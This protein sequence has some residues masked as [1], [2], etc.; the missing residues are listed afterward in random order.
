MTTT[1]LNLSTQ[2]Q[3]RKGKTAFADI[4][5]GKSNRMVLKEVVQVKTEKSRHQ[6]AVSIR[7]QLKYVVKT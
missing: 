3:I 1:K 2:I 5:V 6:Y 4:C 7:G